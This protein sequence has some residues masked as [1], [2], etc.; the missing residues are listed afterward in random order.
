[1]QI[2]LFGDGKKRGLRISIFITVILILICPVLIILAETAAGG[3]DPSGKPPAGTNSP[4]GNGTAIVYKSLPVA[5][6]DVYTKG[7]LLIV[8][9]STPVVYYPADSTLVAFGSPTSYSTTSPSMRLNSEAMSALNRMLDT[10]CQGTGDNTVF[11]NSAYRTEAEQAALTSSAVKA[12]YSDHHL[13]LSVAL[14]GQTASGRI[15][16]AKDHWVYQ[17]CHEYGFVLRYPTGKEAITGD[18]QNYDNCIRY[19]GIPH[20]LYMKENDLC[21]EE[22]VSLLKTYTYEGTHLQITANGALYEVYYVPATD[23]GTENAVTTLPIPQDPTTGEPC[24]Y[25]Y[26]GNNTDGFIVTARIG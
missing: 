16:L 3:T 5:S 9:T 22:Y 2:R 1:M 20:A 21:L 14:R 23:L 24:E 13:A 7:S 15:S 26:S 12:G 19:V 17:N 8:N 6:D 10:Y 4:Q 25:T 18:T 11:I